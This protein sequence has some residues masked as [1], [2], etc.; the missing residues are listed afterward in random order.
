VVRWHIGPMASNTAKTAKRKRTAH[1][2]P[3]PRFAALARL[4]AR[5]L[6]RKHLEQAG[7]EKDWPES[8]SGGYDS[9][10]QSGDES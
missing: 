4:L 7:N 1:Q 2:T 10:S 3:D 9:D 8:Q 5:D 6:A